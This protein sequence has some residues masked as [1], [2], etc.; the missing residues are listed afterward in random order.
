ML[1]ITFLIA[2]DCWAHDNARRVCDILDRF[3]LKELESTL[4]F[5]AQFERT[6]KKPATR[7]RSRRHV[8]DPLRARVIVEIM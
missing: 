8:C 5:R 7:R 6:E 1:M 3:S 2:F 4:H